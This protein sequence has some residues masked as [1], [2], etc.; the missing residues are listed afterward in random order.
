M[1]DLRHDPNWSNSP[2]SGVTVVPTV[3]IGASQCLL[4][5]FMQWDGMTSIHSVSSSEPETLKPLRF[6]ISQP[7]VERY[8]T[9][10]DT[11]SQPIIVGTVDGRILHCR[12]WKAENPWSWH[13]WFAVSTTAVFINSALPSFHWFNRKIITCWKLQRGT[14]DLWMYSHLGLH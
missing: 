13:L 2:I 7:V 6:W 9:N 8:W 12:W 10:H 11:N 3:L 5:R 1:A 4:E 14:P